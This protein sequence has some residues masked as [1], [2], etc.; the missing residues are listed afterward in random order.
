MAR[1]RSTLHLARASELPA[2]SRWQ[3]QVINAPR[4]SQPTTEEGGGTFVCLVRVTSTTW[5]GGHFFYSFFQMRNNSLVVALKLAHSLR[6]PGNRPF[7]RPL[8]SIYI[9][10]WRQMVW[11][12]C[13]CRFTSEMQSLYK[14]LYRDDWNSS[15][16]TS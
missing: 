2:H 7:M 10:Q 12:L 4:E 5:E 15:S 1:A 16:F 11:L 3:S 8:N 13:S 6:L 9:K 14:T